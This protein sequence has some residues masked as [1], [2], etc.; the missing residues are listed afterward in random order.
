MWGKILSAAQKLKAGKDFKAASNGAGNVVGNIMS[1]KAK[2]LAIKVGGGAGISIIVFVIIAI[3]ML[4][5]IIMPW[6][7]VDQFLSTIKEEW[8]E[9]VDAIGNLN[10]SEEYCGNRICTSFD[11]KQI[12]DKS[13]V[14]D[15]RY[16]DI[17]KVDINSEAILGTSL[18]N[19]DMEEYYENLTKD[20]VTSKEKCDKEQFSNLNRSK[21]RQT[22]VEQGY[23]EYVSHMGSYISS[24]SPYQANQKL[25]HWAW[26]NFYDDEPDENSAV[27][28][29]NFD[30]ES[31]DLARLSKW[32]TKKETTN[33]C[34]ITVCD[35]DVCRSYTSFSNLH[36][37]EE[38]YSVKDV[39]SYFGDLKQCDEE[40]K[41][42]GGT[43]SISSS[44]SYTLD[45]KKY[46]DYLYNKYLRDKYYKELNKEKEE[47]V[48]LKVKNMMSDI[49]SQE[50]Y[51]KYLMYNDSTVVPF[52]VDKWEQEW[53]YCTV[54]NGEY[55]YGFKPEDDRYIPNTMQCDYTLGVQG[56]TQ[57]TTQEVS[58]IKV[59]VLNCFTQE[60]D[61]E[62]IDFEKYVLGVAYGELDTNKPYGDGG[63]VPEE[64]VKSLAVA[65]RS[66]A[67][68]R[69]QNRG[70]LVQE[71][72][73]WV[74]SIKNCTDDQVYCDP[75]IGCHSIGDKSALASGSGANGSYYKQPLDQQW[76]KDAVASTAGQVIADSSGNPIE[77][78][79]GSNKVTG[80]LGWEGNKPIIGNIPDSWYGLADSG[81][82]YNE[83][84]MKAYAG[85]GA[86][87]I[88]D[89]NCLP[90]TGDWA[91]WKQ[92]DPTWGNQSINP[93]EDCSDDTLASAGCALTSVAIQLARSGATLNQE[94]VAKYGGLNPGTF[95]T[96]LAE[97]GGFTCD[98]IYWGATTNVSSNFVNVYHEVF[99]Y[100]YTG[101]EAAN[102]VAQYA[103]QGYYVVIG[104][105]NKG[106][107]VAVDKVIGD[108]IYVFDPSNT[109]G[110]LSDLYGDLD[111][112]AV[113]QIEVY[114]KTG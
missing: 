11:E 64:A 62:L 113:Y 103:N 9:F 15:E 21:V 26:D 89:P 46:D 114:Q 50:V 45:K 30:D 5:P 37:D 74:L 108:D 85:D 81:L 34:T 80:V 8:K 99:D 25:G 59:R 61:E 32:S 23:G 19:E 7:A 44:D 52:Q 16:S 20:C 31:K 60:S 29:F 63:R 90:S 68:A 55:D 36:E 100:G 82:D 110:I 72:D 58:N 76:F 3:I 112:G 75:D 93:F 2:M 14:I 28:R 41:A 48:D 47:F 94:F 92:Y 17:Y 38:N 12:Y 98:N 106:H 83:I 4:L 70:N 96:A 39:I 91:N 102:I 73:Q 22:I 6:L 107:Y 10:T 1:K 53:E 111:G 84:L 13:K 101:S 35:G 65:A 86:T 27:K 18:Y 78:Q 104:V 69:A 43:A 95:A 49:Y 87:G 79:Y 71:G 67:L 51:Y 105:K 57:V 33:T 40:A 66:F 109:N 42:V 24:N 77:V 97:N 54:C 88:T 56:D